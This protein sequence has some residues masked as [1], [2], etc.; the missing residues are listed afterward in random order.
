VPKKDAARDRG[1]AGAVGDRTRFGGRCASKRSCREPLPGPLIIHHHPPH[2]PPIVH[3]QSSPGNRDL[4]SQFLAP[5]QSC[6]GLALDGR[7]TAVASL[8]ATQRFVTAA[9]A[10]LPYRV[11]KLASVPSPPSIHVVIYGRSPAWQALH[12]W[13]SAGRTESLP[14][15]SSLPADSL[16]LPSPLDVLNRPVH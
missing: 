4:H 2:R 8:D 3:S 5:H 7:A 10:T 14:Y 1:E 13:S 11:P 12:S 16:F 6:P 15:P 9:A